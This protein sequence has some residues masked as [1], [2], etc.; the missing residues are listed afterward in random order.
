M[1]WIL[2]PKVSIGPLK[3]GMSRNDVHRIFGEPDQ[4]IDHTKSETP[5]FYERYR[6]RGFNLCFKGNFIT[7]EL[8]S[9]DMVSGNVVK[10]EDGDVLFPVCIHR[11]LSTCPMDIKEEWRHGASIYKSYKNAIC[12]IVD[13][14]DFYAIRFSA[15]KEIKK[16]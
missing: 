11:L 6:Q 9:V 8:L 15:H 3:F 4:I 13:D 10:T 14:K 5:S 1:E 12:A 16:K 2:K 7:N